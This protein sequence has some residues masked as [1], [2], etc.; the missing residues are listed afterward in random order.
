MSDCCAPGSGFPNAAL[1][2]QM[3]TNNSVVWEEICML[4]QAILAASSQCQI[5]GGQMCT[6]VGGTTPMTFVS[7]V[8]A[9]NVID[10]GYGY[11]QDNPAI[12]FVPPYGSV[13]S[14]LATGTLSTNG[15]NIT[16]VTVTDG[17]LGYQPLPATLSVS[18]LAGADAEL[19]P[20]VNYAG[21]IVS[22]NIVSGGL[23]Y[24][25]S[26]SVIATRAVEPNAAYVDAVFLITSVSVIGEI[27]SVIVLNPG[28]GYQDSVATVNIVSAINPPI[29][30]PL[31]T[32]FQASVLTDLLGTVTGVVISNPGYGY[33]AMNPYLVISDPGTG[34]TT[35][36][37][38]TGAEIQNTVGSISVLTSGT[39]YTQLA[40]GEVLN[41]STV[42]IPDT[43]AEVSIVVSNNT[44]GT[45]PSLYW[46]VWAGVATNKPISAQLNSV[47]TYF[48][49][50]GYT[51]LIQTNPATTNTIQWK[52]CW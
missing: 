17:G 34:A 8:T 18:S 33:S 30:Y 9:V 40:T 46:Q 41:P 26:D 45:T 42:G 47:L 49:S 36:V 24:T 43:P 14:S 19:Q 52:I 48:K 28:S 6:I 5:G 32:G 13:G 27:L 10:P 25:T 29:P 37:T 38:L 39:N 4:Q 7:G 1:M 35:Q 21:N 50:L 22:V 23:G 31:G 3:A 2:Q 51:I 12:E 15:G 20:L 11:Y 16:Q 44:Y